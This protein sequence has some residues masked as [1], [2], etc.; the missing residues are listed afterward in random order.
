ML[1]GFGGNILSN[2]KFQSLA[3]QHEQLHDELA[4]LISTSLRGEIRKTT[5]AVEIYVPNGSLIANNPDLKQKIENKI[6]SSYK[7]IQQVN[8]ISGGQITE[9]A[10]SISSTAGSLVW[11]S[12]ASAGNLSESEQDSR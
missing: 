12:T 4:S 11:I 6:K 7:N 10:Q 2:Q 9:L 3:N 1:E 8:I 5:Q